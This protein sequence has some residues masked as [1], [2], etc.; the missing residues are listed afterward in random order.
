M[1]INLFIETIM[2]NFKGNK[3][4]RIIRESIQYPISYEQ[5]NSLYP[6]STNSKTENKI[7]QL[8]LTSNQPSYFT[9]HRVKFKSQIM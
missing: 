9:N 5:K 7:K 4:Y 2:A 6:K 1:K 3:N 8:S